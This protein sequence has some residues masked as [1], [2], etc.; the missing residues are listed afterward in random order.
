[1]EEIK[2]GLRIKT[3]PDR[4]TVG[5]I[6]SEGILCLKSLVTIDRDVTPL[7]NKLEIDE[8]EYPFVTFKHLIDGTIFMIEFKKEE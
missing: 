3:L 2:C 6:S 4:L 7:R 1:M 8:T 5:A